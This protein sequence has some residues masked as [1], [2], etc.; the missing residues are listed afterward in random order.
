MFKIATNLPSLDAC[1]L[2]KSAKLWKTLLL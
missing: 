2:Q 1:V